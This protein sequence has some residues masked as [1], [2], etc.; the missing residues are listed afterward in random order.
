MLAS[1]A[2]RSDR[3]VSFIPGIEGECIHSNLQVIRKLQKLECQL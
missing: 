2:A 1:W 3:F